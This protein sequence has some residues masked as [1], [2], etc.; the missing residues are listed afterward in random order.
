M[1][2]QILLLGAFAI[3]VGFAFRARKAGRTPARPVRGWLQAVALILLAL[4][5][6]FFALFGF[7]EIF[8][9]DLRG[10]IHLLPMVIALQLIRIARRLPLESGAVLTGLGI[11]TSVFY[12]FQAR[13]GGTP[14]LLLGLPW[15]VIGLVLLAAVG[16]PGHRAGVHPSSP[17]G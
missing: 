4:Y 9:G 10:A 8:S 5:A 13:G 17:R 6:A 1:Q 11:L 3:L 14:M 7:G 15:M 16:L 12:A 2:A